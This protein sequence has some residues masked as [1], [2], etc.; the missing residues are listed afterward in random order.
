MARDTGR[1]P[2]FNAPWPALVIAGSIVVSYAAQTALF[3]DPEAVRNRWGLVPYRLATGDVGG[4]LTHMLVHGGWVHALGNA[5]FALVCAAPLARLLGLSAGRALALVGFYIVCGAMAGGLYAGFVEAVAGGV[6]PGIRLSDKIVLIGASGA[7]SGLMGAAAR[8]LGQGGRL[9][10]MFSRSALGLVLGLTVVN[11]IVGL[12]G[13][14]P[15][16]DT[17]SPIAWPVHI[18]GLFIGL[19]LIGP[20]LALFGEGGPGRLRDAHATPGGR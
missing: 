20:W 19:F 1:E 15:G 18:I 4:L 12:L 6:L 16:V 8:T 10:P 13:F 7:V 3:G 11:V 5:F 2:M 9:G 14:T 17:G